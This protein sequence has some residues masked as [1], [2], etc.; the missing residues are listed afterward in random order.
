MEEEDGEG[1]RSARESM[2]RFVNDER[3]CDKGKKKKIAERRS[4]KVKEGEYNKKEVQMWRER[5][6]G[7]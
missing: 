1:S 7:I 5:R 4:R 3:K 2:K 6:C